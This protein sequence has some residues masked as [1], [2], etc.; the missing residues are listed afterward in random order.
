M[1]IAIAQDIAVTEPDQLVHRF[2]RE[3]YHRMADAGL[4]S[5]KRVELLGGRIFDMPPQDES[6]VNSVTDLFHFFSDNLSRDRYRVRCQAPVET[7]KYSEPEP[8]FAITL[9][10]TKRS[11][12]HPDTAILVVEVSNTTLARDRNKAATYARAGVKE[13]WIVNLKSRTIE[14]YTQPRAKPTARY[15]TRRDFKENEAIQCTVLPLPPLP[16][17]ECLRLA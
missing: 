2:T 5:E 6:H 12:Q 4:F 3:E 7:D 15:A 8:D 1:T 16:V 9:V 13:Y 17:M 14:Q 11:K 10:P